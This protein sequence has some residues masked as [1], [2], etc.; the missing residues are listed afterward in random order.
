MDSYFHFHRRIVLK[1][2]LLLLL[3][4]TT[5]LPYSSAARALPSTGQISSN[6]VLVALLDS[7]YSDLSELLEKALLLPVLE[8]A[9][10]SN[11]LTIFAPT[12]RAFDL[13][14][15]P[16]FKRFLL[17]PSNLPSLQSLILHHIL[18][19]RIGYPTRNRQLTL[20]NTHLL[21]RREGS[22]GFLVESTAVIHRA[23][24]VR[25]DGVVHGIDNVLVPQTV[26]DEFN[27]RRSLRS[28]A[29]VHPEGAPVADPRNPRK[30]Q[31]EKN[32]SPPGRLSIYEAM[33]PGMAPASAPAP[34]PGGAHGRLDGE[35]LVQDFISTLMSYGGY[36]EV[37]DILVNL[38]TVA[39][40][41]GRLVSE[42]YTVTILAPNDEA[43]TGLTAEQLADP[44]A[45]EELMYYHIIPEYQTEESM[46]SAVRRFGKL[47]YETLRLQ[48]KLVAAEADGSVKFGEGKGRSSAY[49]FDP[50]IYTDGRISVQGIDGVLFPPEKAAAKVKS[51]VPVRKIVAR[52]RREKEMNVLVYLGLNMLR[53]HI[54]LDPKT[55]A[56]KRAATTNDLGSTSAKDTDRLKTFRKALDVVRAEEEPYMPSRVLRQF[57]RRQVVP[58]VLI[59]PSFVSRQIGPTMYKIQFVG[60]DYHRW[61][62][63]DTHLIDLDAFELCRWA[64]DC[65]IGYLSYHL[66][67]THPYLDPT[68]PTQDHPR[69][70]AIFCMPHVS[71]A[72]VQNQIAIGVVCTWLGDEGISDEEMEHLH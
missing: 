15:D 37:A 27:R 23:D 35:R 5:A 11:N 16:E 40:E 14:F 20:S 19:S 25:S 63:Q 24:I 33:A 39:S 3:C 45:P 34:G 8:R 2:L 42:G 1:R 44:G 7:A 36:N 21:L 38:T 12:N 28:I 55:F 71:D 69:D 22:G 32:S 43:M 59:K 53:G 48:H 62:D 17:Q 68:S 60:P 65:D 41:V 31:K 50:D 66:D 10:D 26:L 52:P 4:F 49:L 9:L 30:K 47:R 70:G 51:A 57:G 29:A 13:S 54:S 72:K 61:A 18:P 64:W 67:I 6:S 58:P 56:D 46:Y